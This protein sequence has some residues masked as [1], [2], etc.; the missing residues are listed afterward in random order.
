MMF[1]EL[2]STGSAEISRFHALSA[3]NIGQP[4]RVGPPENAITIGR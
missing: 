1:W 3:G 2:G 4:P